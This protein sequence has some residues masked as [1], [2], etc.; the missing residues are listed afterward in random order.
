MNAI[1]VAIAKRGACIAGDLI[2]L[3]LAVAAPSKSKFQELPT[4]TITDHVV[5]RN[6]IEPVWVRPPLSNKS[7][8]RGDDR[9]DHYHGQHIY[10]APH[11]RCDRDQEQERMHPPEVDQ[12]AIQMLKRIIPTYTTEGCR[13]EGLGLPPGDDEQGG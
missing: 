2:R 11:T 12:N 7:D 10:P 8:R 3:T 13:E 5:N 9:T 1:K 4:A 6:N